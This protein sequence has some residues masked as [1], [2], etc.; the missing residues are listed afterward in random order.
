MF[1]IS[2][3]AYSV[4][5]QTQQPRM[6]DKPGRGTLGKL[7][8]HGYGRKGLLEPARHF[9][10]SGFPYHPQRH[11]E[12]LVGKGQEVGQ[13]YASQGYWIGISVIK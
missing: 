10:A 5:V 4:K 8:T 6:P 9:L 1:G 7:A 12:T 2:D 11:V 13:K 3:I